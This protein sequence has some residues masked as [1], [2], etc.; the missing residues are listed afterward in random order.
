MGCCL[1]RKGLRGFWSLQED[2]V[3]EKKSDYRYRPREERR[4]EEE[5]EIETFGEERGWLASGRRS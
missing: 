5:C 1:R 3:D 2:G 4:V